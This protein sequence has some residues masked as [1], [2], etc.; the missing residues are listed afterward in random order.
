ME[1][2]E[3]QDTATLSVQ[4]QDGER[5]LLTLT[6]PLDFHN[7]ARLWDK[8]IGALSHH[9]FGQIVIDAEKIRSCD[10]G[11]LALLFEIQLW[12]R[13]HGK[14]MELHGLKKEYA[15]LLK[16]FTPE[17]FLAHRTARHK[18]IPFPE[19]IGRATVEFWQD[20]QEQ[21]GFIG[22]AFVALV[23]SILRPWRIRWKD[24]FWV[25]EHAGANAVGIVILLGFLFGLIITFSS[26]LPLRQFGVEVYVSDLAALALVR[27]LGPFIT[28]II[29]A[30]R[31]GSAFAAEIGTMKINN[32]IDALETM[33]LDPVRFLVVPRLLATTV[34]TPLLA[35]LANLA[36]IIGSAVVMLSLGFTLRT[37]ITHVES[38]ISPPDVYSGLVKCFV[39]GLLVSGVGCL[40]GLQTE[41]GA[42]AVG[43]STT[44]AV[45]SGIVLVV[46]AEGVFAVLYHFL[47]I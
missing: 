4:S 24:V 29:L 44:R 35:I 36:G 14:S 45:V 15:D 38:A 23:T 33:G 13:E 31:S 9:S 6:G 17:A 30:G 11:G 28:A 25:A 32:E 20:F 39:F 26:A 47:E 22:Q 18:S 40:R 21:V 12:A 34:V 37:F 46:V 8:A 2:L 27:V 41:T 1:A 7:S 42:S 19:E 43:I 3:K 5:L 10:G 16:N